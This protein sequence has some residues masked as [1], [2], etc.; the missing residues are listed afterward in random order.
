MNECPCINCITFPICKA[1]VDEYMKY[2]AMIHIDKVY[3]N[4][5]YDSILKPKC[6]IITKWINNKPIRSI[7]HKRFV[8]LYNI[9][10]YRPED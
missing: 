6:I 7:I 10:R 3:A 2:Y 4:N 5:M 1:Q 8:I 9:Y